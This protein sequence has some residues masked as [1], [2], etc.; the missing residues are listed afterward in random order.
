MEEEVRL[1]REIRRSPEHPLGRLYRNVE[2]HKE[3]LLD[4]EQE[5]IEREAELESFQ[6]TI[7]ENETKKPPHYTYGSYFQSPAYE[8]YKKYVDEKKRLEGNVE[9]IKRNM[10]TRKELIRETEEEIH[11]IEKS[12]EPGK[13]ERDAQMRDRYL[14]DDE[15][16]DT[17]DS[18]NVF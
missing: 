17:I 12:L 11:E 9:F 1:L 16:I 5:L 15:D 7:R 8:R 6:P 13:A 10:E 4:D 2:K 18:A 3:H 14:H